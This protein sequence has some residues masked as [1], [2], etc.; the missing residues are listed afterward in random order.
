[1]CLIFNRES[2]QD[3]KLPVIPLLFAGR[4]DLKEEY[5]DLKT[6]LELINYYLHLWLIVCDFKILNKLLGLNGCWCKEPCFL[7]HWRAH[8]NLIEHYSR[9]GTW[10]KRVPVN[11]KLAR[12]KV[13][14]FF[15][16]LIPVDKVLLP[17]LHI[18]LGTFKQFIK[19]LFAYERVCG[20]KTVK[21]T[22]NEKAI[23]FLMTFFHRK[24]EDKIKSGTFN[25][26]EIRR[27]MKSREEFA[28]C[29]R[30]KEKRC[31]RAFCAVVENF[32]GNYRAPNYKE[33]V[34]EL[35]LAYKDNNVLMSLKTHYLFEHLDYFP[36]NCGSYSEEK[37]ENFHQE[38]K[39]FERRI[40]DRESMVVNF[41]Y[42]KALEGEINLARMPKNK[43]LFFS[44]KTIP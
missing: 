31:W 20:Q 26:P 22:A 18:K 23:S 40:K 16:C 7:C 34:N 1:M 5:R 25:G 13:S 8:L 32:F 39:I 15:N 3:E 38:T 44:R 36:K 2:D 27:L 29:L 28:A 19:S 21:R 35:K 6:A 41:A 43:N 14:V 10:K 17:I 42:A 12:D 11:N 33:L 4:D 37:G 30:P 9:M 24:T